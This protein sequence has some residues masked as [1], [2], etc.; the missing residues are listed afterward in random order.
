MNSRAIPATA[1]RICRIVH[2]G[3][4]RFLHLFLRVVALIHVIF[5][6]SEKLLLIRN[7][8]LRLHCRSGRRRSRISGI[9]RRTNRP[10]RRLRRRTSRKCHASG[11]QHRPN[12]SSSPQSPSSTHRRV[13]CS[14]R[15]AHPCAVD[16][17]RAEEAHLNRARCHK[18][19]LVRIRM[20]KIRVGMQ[21][22]PL[23]PGRRY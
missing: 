17:R 7:H 6:G 8:H 11:A 3:P 13:Q 18:L 1:A 10:R 4:A 15:L 14:H 21:R 9:S 16:Y 12:R 22:H 20:H 19:T 5:P 2:A 23:S